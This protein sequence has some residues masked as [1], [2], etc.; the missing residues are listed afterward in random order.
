MGQISR[1]PVPHLV[2][3]SQRDLVPLS[4]SATPRELPPVLWD[5]LVMKTQG[6]VRNVV[7]WVLA[8]SVVL[9]SPTVFAQARV[10]LPF[11][12]DDQDVR[13]LLDRLNSDPDVAFIVPN[14]PLESDE[15]R[16][17]AIRKLLQ[18]S[19][20]TNATSIVTMGR[21]PT[22]HRQQWRAVKTVDALADGHHALWYRPAGPLPLVK[23]DRM[24]DQSIPDPF[25][26]WT[27]EVPS[28][29]AFEPYFGSSSPAAIRLKLS[30][31]HRPYTAEERK[32]GERIS[33]WMGDRDFLVGS[34]FQHSALSDAWLVRLE[35]WMSTVAA[36]LGGPK[37][38]DTWWAFRSALSK[39]KAGMRY[40]ANGF[41]LD[42]SIR[43][44]QI[45]VR[46]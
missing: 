11:F 44:A 30:T 26:G 18:Q 34:G 21:L 24:S 46:Q 16:A 7:T 1:R 25:A 39:L 13:I 14:G 36:R 6:S 31:R 37:R 27:E 28:A 2:S 20:R 3:Q 5:E 4:A 23:A 33:Y 43:E 42:S 10:W 17:R 38:E 45:P 29:Q 22:D 15:D 12:V 19:G 9:H 35:H 41:N 32:T 40:D 8:A